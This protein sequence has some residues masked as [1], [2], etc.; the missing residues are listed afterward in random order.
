MV[1]EK[2]VTD[3]VEFVCGNPRFDCCSDLGKG[4]C[5]ELPSR[6]HAFNRV[7]VFDF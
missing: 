4:L 2:L 1:A 5:G 3:A 7:G 6:A